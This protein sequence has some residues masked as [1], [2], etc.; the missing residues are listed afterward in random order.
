[1]FI[2]AR[3]RLTPVSFDDVPFA[4]TR[5][6]VI[7]RVPESARRAGHA[8]RTQ[9]RFLVVLTGA[10]RVVVDDGLRSQRLQLGEGETLHVPPAVW[11]QI[12][13]ACDG[14]SILVLADGAYDRS[15][16]VFDRSELP[17]VDRTASHTT[18]A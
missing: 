15:D 11:L 13:A 3:G 12:E 18:A 1:M 4:P 6:Y 2:D 17:M 14:V 10:A 8:C 9:H 5:A 16:Y 7:D